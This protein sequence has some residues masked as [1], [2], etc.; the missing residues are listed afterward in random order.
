LLDISE[1]KSIF[2][3]YLLYKDESLKTD[4]IIHQDI[5]KKINRL[6]KAF[7]TIELLGKSI[8]GKEIFTIPRYTKEN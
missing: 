6:N 1:L 2:D 5:L 3:S 4:R 7:F 8:N